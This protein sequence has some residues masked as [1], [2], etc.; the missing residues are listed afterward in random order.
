MNLYD[1]LPPASG[2]SQTQELTGWARAATQLPEDRDP[3]RPKVSEVTVDTS[4]TAPQ[5]PIPSN[6]KTQTKFLSDA[7]RR[8]TTAAKAAAGAT[9]TVRSAVPSASTLPSVTIEAPNVLQN[10][11]MTKPESISDSLPFGSGPVW[12]AGS[13]PKRT[14]RGR[15]RDPME[16]EYDPSKPNSYEEVKAIKRHRRAARKA[17]LLQEAMGQWGR[18][19]VEAEENVPSNGWGRRNFIDHDEAKTVVQSYRDEGHQIPA[20]ENS[21]EGAKAPTVSLPGEDLSGEDA[22]LRRAQ[23]SFSGAPSRAAASGVAL[24]TRTRSCVICLLNLVDP[25]EVDDS[26]ETEISEE[27]SKFGQVEK[28]L[29]F[30]AP[31]APRDGAVRV[32]VKFREEDNADRGVYLFS[33]SYGRVNA[34]L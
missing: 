25:G 30:E 19:T 6:W 26:F 14:N 4:E 28:V 8:K 10:V 23:I 7:L 17:R 29:I 9:P 13:G 15:K 27:C 32:F 12:T 20:K 5:P 2:P 3:E 16:E 18:R 21:S 1:D 33:R 24:P 31:K 22:F 11:A 34:Q